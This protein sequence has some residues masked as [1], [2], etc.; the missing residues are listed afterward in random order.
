MA[1]FNAARNALLRTRQNDK[2]LIKPPAGVIPNY[3]DPPSKGYRVVAVSLTFGLLALSFV[4][5][6][7]VIKKRV[8]KKFGWDD[9]K[10]PPSSTLLFVGSVFA[11]LTL[12]K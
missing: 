8:V 3:I 12:A 11:S 10:M 7:V 6:R 5:I 2:Y 1:A 4:V 9:C